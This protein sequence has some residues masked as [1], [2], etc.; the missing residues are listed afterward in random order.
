VKVTV[1]VAVDETGRVVDAEMRDGDGSGLGF[2]EA[3]LEAAR[4][5]T[6]F[7]ATR[8]G[9]EGRMWTELSFEFVE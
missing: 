9:I 5:T 6:F 4:K 8:D 7:P 2:D 1:R 3:A